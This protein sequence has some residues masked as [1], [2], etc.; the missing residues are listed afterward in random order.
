MYLLH[1]SRRQW[2]F[3]YLKQIQRD[4]A[5]DGQMMGRQL[6]RR[7]QNA[8]GGHQVVRVHRISLRIVR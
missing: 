4:Y 5:L 8:F 6:H 1:T 3:N 2:N 7:L